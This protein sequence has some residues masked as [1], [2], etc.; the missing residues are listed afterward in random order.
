MNSVQ[1]NK[2]NKMI[3]PFLIQGILKVVDEEI[4]VVNKIWIKNY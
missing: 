4:C 3:K 1:Y 2:F